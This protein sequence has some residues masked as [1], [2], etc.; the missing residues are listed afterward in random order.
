[1]WIKVNMKFDSFYFHNLTYLKV[2][3]NIQAEKKNVEQDV[4][5]R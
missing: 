5:E 2:K 3:Q 1:M 4:L